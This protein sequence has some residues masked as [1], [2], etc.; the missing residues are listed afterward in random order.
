MTCREVDQWGEVCGGT[1]SVERDGDWLFTECDK[2]GVVRSRHVE[3]ADPELKRQLRLEQAGIP[4]RFIGVKFDQTR[5]NESALFMARAWIAD[6]KKGDGLPAPAL[7]GPPGRG[8]SHLLAGIG[9]RLVKEC[10]KRVLVRS[11]RGLLRE[12][13]QFED[14]AAQ[15]WKR[16]TTVDVLILDDVGAQQDTDWRQDQLADLVDARYEAELPIVLATNF[17]PKAWADVLDARTA[18]RLRGMTFSVE[19]RGPDRRQLAIKEEVS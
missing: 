9:I 2:C 14:G 8:K 18:S 12:L 17:A 15:A 13:Q 4:K 10:D 7:W 6:V 1:V 11:A 3:T 19:L 16:A 5:D